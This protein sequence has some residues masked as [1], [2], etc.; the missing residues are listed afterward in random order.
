MSTVFNISIYTWYGN[1]DN[2]WINKVNEV[3]NTEYIIAHIIGHQ[4][5][6][7]KIC[8]KIG[9]TKNVDLLAVVQRNSLDKARFRKSS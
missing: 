7:A 6:G 3:L 5:E 8:P 9:E 1:L 4:Y 2:G